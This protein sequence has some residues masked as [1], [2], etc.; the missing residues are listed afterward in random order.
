M[1]AGLGVKVAAA[2]SL[3]GGS[4]LTG[5][6]PSCLGLGKGCGQ[7]LM[8]SLVLCCGAGVLFATS[9]I[10]IL[11]EARVQL[12]TWADVLFCIGFMV[13]YTTDEF[14]KLFEPTSDKVHCHLEGTFLEM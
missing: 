9:I 10:H 6:L 1:L 5:T 2:V 13:L 14:V 3:A 8:L 7:S 12:P 11:P 4:Y